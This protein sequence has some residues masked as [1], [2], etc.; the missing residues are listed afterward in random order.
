MKFLS[1]ILGSIF[2]YFEASVLSK[3][4][5]EVRIDILTL[6]T[7]VI[8]NLPI[9]FTNGFAYPINHPFKNISFTCGHS[10]AQ[11]WHI[12]TFSPFVCIFSLVVN[13][14]PLNSIFRITGV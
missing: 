9:I 10:E 7:L 11:V 1:H 5:S 8:Y 4:H 13:F 14:S 12:D 2:E 6:L 3:G